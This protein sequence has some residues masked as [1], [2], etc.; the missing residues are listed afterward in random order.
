MSSKQKSIS[1]ERLPLDTAD[2]ADSDHESEDV[3]VSMEN[4]PISIPLKWSDEYEDPVAFEDGDKEKYSKSIYFA[5]NDNGLFINLFEGYEWLSISEY[6]DRK[7][8]TQIVSPLTVENAENGGNIN[9]VSYSK[10]AVCSQFAAIYQFVIQLLHSLHFD[11]NDDDANADKV[12]YPWNLIY[13]QRKDNKLPILSKNRSY[14]V[15]LFFCGEWRAILIDDSMPMFGGKLLFP[16][17]ADSN[18]I[19]PQLLTK[20]ILK[21]LILSNR[22]NDELSVPLIVQLLTAVTPTTLT[23]I[24]SLEDA[25]DA[26]ITIKYV[27]N[28]DERYKIK[29]AINL[30]LI[31]DW[32]VCAAL[33]NFAISDEIIQNEE[34]RVIVHCPRY[35]QQSI[36]D[37]W[38]NENDSKY[39]NDKT[40]IIS[41]AEKETDVILQIHSLNKNLSERVTLFM[42][43]QQNNI[44]RIMK[45]I[46]TKH[47]LG[48]IIAS[49]VPHQIYFVEVDGNISYSI[50]LHSPSSEVQISPRFGDEKIWSVIKQN[51]IH[52]AAES[53]RHSVGQTFILFNVH[54]QVL[55]KD[56]NVIFH[57]VFADELLSRSLILH[58][59]NLDD[60]SFELIANLNLSTFNLPSNKVNKKICIFAE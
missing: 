20:A 28:L 44:K 58:C 37:L 49:I 17:I 13:P 46:N 34:N 16:N 56:C 14:F 50:T 15:K 2:D 33:N 19:W 26:K 43:D 45:Q 39:T 41:N 29:Q 38:T 23:Q 35:H 54:I 6:Y 47:S 52:I 9:L 36:E 57:S 55:S 12:I 7:Q 24:K 27:A 18:E 40:V 32:S 1:Q 51:V 60:H 10:L 3:Q 4:F 11:D 21:F 30:N 53:K 8:T 59:V 42:Y 48:S 22:L 25:K 5:K 31:K